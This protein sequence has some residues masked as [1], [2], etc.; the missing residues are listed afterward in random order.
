MR[1]G[2]AQDP[3][4]KISV[5]EIAASPTARRQ[6]PTTPRPASA[7]GRPHETAKAHK[8]KV[9]QHL[10][11]AFKH[12]D[13]AKKAKP[14]L[15]NPF[16][17]TASHT[18]ALP[19]NPKRLTIDQAHQAMKQMG[20]TPAEIT[21]KSPREVKDLVYAGAKIKGQVGAAKRNPVERSLPV[22]L[23]TGEEAGRTSPGD[24]FRGSERNGRGDGIF[25]GNQ[26]TGSLG[27][28][29]LAPNG[30]VGGGGGSGNGP[31]Q[32]TKEEARRDFSKEKGASQQDFHVH[33]GDKV[34]ELLQGMGFPVKEPLP[35]IETSS[36]YL[37]GKKFDVRISDGHD[38]KPKRQSTPRAKPEYQLT[39][40]PGSSRVSATKVK[41]SSFRTLP[42]TTAKPSHESSALDH[43]RYLPPGPHFLRGT[44]RSRVCGA[45]SCPMTTCPSAARSFTYH[46]TA[47]ST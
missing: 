16:G 28:A 43:R 13:A 2:R 4:G 41:T 37:K 27:K 38:A 7:P 19:K 23:H 30:N 8:E 14:L 25:Y 21:S 11:T 45:K 3:Q 9:H 17:H 36:V 40:P 5:H 1:R 46:R 39:I 18:I 22:E 44:P 29:K 42:Q 12:D 31:K 33:V 15:I 32:I 47:C 35:A 10:L 24:P 6:R 34:R 26:H 20:Y